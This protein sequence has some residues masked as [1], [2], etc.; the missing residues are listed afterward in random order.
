MPGIETRMPLMFD[1]MVSRG[2]LGLAAFVNLTA[3]QPA[4]LYGLYPRKGSIEVGADADLAI[5][6]PQR[7]VTLSSSMTHD[8]TGYCPYEGRVVKGWPEV[9]IRRG[10]VIVADGKLK[11]APGTG[12]FIA[13]QAGDA[14]KPTGC[15]GAELDP[16]R[17][18]GATLY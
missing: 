6:N 15:C 4:R 2:K 11:A 7:E 16:V 17:N 8:R 9:V 14:A 10:Q 5:W 3:T 13:R 1:A 18:F 12:Q